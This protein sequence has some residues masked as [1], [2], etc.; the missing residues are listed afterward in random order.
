MLK[1]GRE[2]GHPATGLRVSV[3]EPSP[4]RDSSHESVEPTSTDRVYDGVRHV[5]ALKQQPP[6]WNSMMTAL[7]LELLAGFTKKAYSLP[8]LHRVSPPG[9]IAV[10]FDAEAAAQKSRLAQ[11]RAGFIVMQ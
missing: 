10:H 4:P 2:T 5:S 1:Y 3:S 11:K 6:P 8:W 9:L 7:L